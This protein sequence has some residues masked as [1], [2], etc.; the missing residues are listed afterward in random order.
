MYRRLS[1]ASISLL[2]A[3]GGGGSEDS[4]PPDDLFGGYAPASLEL[5]LLQ[6]IDLLAPLSPAPGIESFTVTPP[7]PA[8]LLLDGATGEISG[9]AE[10]LAPLTEYLITAE[11]GSIQDSESL[12]LSVRPPQITLTSDV[13][14][15]RATML[16]GTPSSPS[17]ASLPAP[18]GA[19][20]AQDLAV[21]VLDAPLPAT[22]DLVVLETPPGAPEP[23]SNSLHNATVDF[24]AEIT[25]TSTEL[26]AEP[27]DLDLAAPYAGTSVPLDL[28]S[29]LL[30][31]AVEPLI[32]GDLALELS[33]ATPPVAPFVSN[34]LPTRA[35]AHEPLTQGL[36]TISG[37]ALAAGPFAYF[38]ASEDIIHQD[39]YRYSEA[40]PFLER[41][42]DVETAGGLFTTLGEALDDWLVFESDLGAGLEKPLLLD[43]TNET[44]AQV[45]DLN[46]T[47]S[48]AADGFV[49][50]GDALYFL[51][52]PTFSERHV[53]RFTPAAEPAPAGLDRISF[54]ATG[55]D[56]NPAEITPFEGAVY[57]TAL[58][59][60]TGERHLFR[61]SPETLEQERLSSAAQANISALQ[62]AG[63]ELFVVA[64]GDGGTQKLH[65]FDTGTNNLIQIADLAGDGTI[66]DQISFLQGSQSRLLFEARSPVGTRKLFVYNP[67]D[68]SL[69]QAS[70]T[71]GDS[72]NDSILEVLEVGDELIFAARNELSAS[73][74]YR[75]NLL[76]GEHIQITDANGSAT[77]DS[78][79]DFI[80]RSDG[81]LVLAMDL[82]STGGF[83][84]VQLDPGPPSFGQERPLVTA[85][86]AGPLE[87]D[88]VTPLLELNGRLLFRA[89]PTTARRI[90]AAD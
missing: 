55:G 6:P 43:T 21:T 85:D 1:L 86:P 7:L 53:Y 57:Y 3:C 2:C 84:L 39:L 24:T 13:P 70:N 36:A 90:Y 76:T 78:P 63:G 51:A 25:V 40:G 62:V 5:V 83:S 73:K 58:H 41:I 27:F 38:V 22:I 44:L 60:A 59:A 17:A 65:R 81:S 79:C 88:D 66:S 67:L 16:A 77:D 72:A 14:L 49:R 10:A 35:P 9:A 4:L 30:D 46:P 68:Q 54:T 48:D 56:D 34:A 82:D 42:T 20:I 74:L 11:A 32:N 64:L 31:T 15:V 71:A 75:T 26:A 18:S 45:S 28:T 23:A 69:L 47:G 19:P 12:I 61:F 87:Q 52:G 37:D 80:L 29:F 50:L 33:L 8:G 89:G